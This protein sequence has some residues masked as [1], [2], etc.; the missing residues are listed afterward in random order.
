MDKHHRG[1]DAIH[2]PATCPN[3]GSTAIATINE[4][5]SFQYGKEGP[6]LEAVVP[7]HSCSE[8]GFQYT[9]S[10]AEDARDHAVREHL[11]VQ[12]P[13]EIV[14]IRKGHGL[15]RA[16]FCEI[17][18]FGLASLPRWESGILIPNVANARYMFLLSFTD[19]IDRL[20]TRYRQGRKTA[21]ADADTERRCRGFRAIT[22]VARVSDCAAKWKLRMPAG[23]EVTCIQ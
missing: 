12:L 14:A 15:S 1:T 2:Q 20:K 21:T 6:Q 13:E 23:G 3:C 10:A 17:S 4:R 19:N 11:D 16:D 9:D 5:Q 8:C 18:G 22:D 7:V